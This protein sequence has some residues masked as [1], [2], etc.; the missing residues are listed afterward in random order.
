[1]KQNNEIISNLF[2]NNF[3]SHV[4]TVFMDVSLKC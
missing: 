2:Q 1:V 4:N 3:M